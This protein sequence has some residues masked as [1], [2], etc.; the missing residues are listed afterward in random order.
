MY[1]F[2]FSLVRLFEFRDDQ[3]AEAE[4]YREIETLRKLII[5]HYILLNREAPPWLFLGVIDC[6]GIPILSLRLLAAWLLFYIFAYNRVGNRKDGRKESFSDTADE[7][8]KKI[9]LFGFDKKTQES[10]LYQLKETRQYIK[11]TFAYKNTRIFAVCM[12]FYGLNLAI[13]SDSIV[14][15]IRDIILAS[16]S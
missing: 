14:V 1:K 6:W 7:I 13:F 9:K 12:F 8:E 2:L 11:G 5:C 10:M 16:L 3:E 15:S 4:I